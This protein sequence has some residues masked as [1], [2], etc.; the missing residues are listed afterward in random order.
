MWIFRL[1]VNF[2]FLKKE[3]EEALALANT[4]SLDTDLVY[5]TQWRK[6][7]FSLNDIQEHLSKVSKRSWVLNECVTR[8]PESLEA[9]RELLNFGLKGA[10]LETLLAIGDKDEGKFVADEVLD[11]WESLNQVDLNL[12][13]VNFIFDSIKWNNI[14]FR[15]EFRASNP[16]RL[17]F[18][19]QVQRINEIINA[20]DIKNLSNAQK[21]LIKYRRKLLDH[22]DKLQTYEIILE[23]P[24]KYKKIFYEEF[25]Q[26]TAIENAVRWEKKM[27]FHKNQ[28]NRT[29]IFLF[30]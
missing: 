30:I 15:N 17:S 28:Y 23:D 8:V 9:A 10:N 18:F 26:L 1:D 16:F 20:I 19:I 6:S 14:Y 25:R 3:Y 21:D 4:Y 7:Q 2:F 27:S 29:L 12:R 5:Q 24:Q 13:Q 11:D 22:L